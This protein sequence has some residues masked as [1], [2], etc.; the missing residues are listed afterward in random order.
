M[1]SAL[2]ATLAMSILP[3][4]LRPTTT[5]VA[6]VFPASTSTFDVPGSPVPSGHSVR[7]VVAV[8]LATV[9][10]STMAVAPVG[11]LFAPETCQISS[12]WLDEKCM[13][14]LGAYRLSNARTG[15]MGVN[16]L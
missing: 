15:V 13:F 6:I 16:A 10:L 14:W 7:N 9:K 11:M 1:M 3:A 12:S 8:A 4:V 5:V 2:P